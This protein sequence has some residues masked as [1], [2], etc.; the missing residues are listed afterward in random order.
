MS[1]VK[2][3][4]AVKIVSE[5]SFHTTLFRQENKMPVIIT[6]MSC[7]DLLMSIGHAKPS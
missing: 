2:F 1:G 5:K 3:H 4:K 6:K 7:N